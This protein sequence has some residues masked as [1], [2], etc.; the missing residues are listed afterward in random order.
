MLFLL[1]AQA[2]MATPPPPVSTSVASLISNDDY[3]AEALRNDWQGRVKVRLRIGTDGR[4]RAC[5]VVQSSG[6]APL[7]LKTCEIMLVR[8]RF[9]PARDKDGHAVED[10]FLSPPI[11]WLI[12]QEAKPEP[13]QGERK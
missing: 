5:R 12:E 11:V 9:T 2:V 1:I 6:H 4:V 7:D 3:P 8:A 13:Q 10:D